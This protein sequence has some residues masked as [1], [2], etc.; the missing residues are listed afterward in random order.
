MTPWRTSTHER[1]FTREGNYLVGFIYGIGLVLSFQMQDDLSLYYNTDTYESPRSSYVQVDKVIWLAKKSENED[2]PWP[3]KV[4]W[5]TKV[6]RSYGG[7][8]KRQRKGA[9]HPV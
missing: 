3:D 5:Q 9:V 8:G 7:G 6:I 4:M 1:P 2:N